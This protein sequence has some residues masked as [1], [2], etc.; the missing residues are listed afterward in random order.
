M[1]DNGKATPDGQ[2]GTD[3]IATLRGVLTLGPKADEAAIVEA[4]Q[5]LVA[6]GRNAAAVADELHKLKVK[7]TRKT[8]DELVKKYLD[9]GQLDP[10]DRDRMKWARDRALNDPDGFKALMDGAAVVVTRPTK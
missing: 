2:S 9:S 5:S 10:E 3:L 4:V 6:K 1:G 7:I 8:A